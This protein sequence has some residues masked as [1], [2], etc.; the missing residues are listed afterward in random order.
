[1]DALSIGAVASQVSQDHQANPILLTNRTKSTLNPYTQDY[2]TAHPELTELVLVGGSK[3]LASSLETTL[4]QDFSN[5]TSISRLSGPNRFDT[6]LAIVEHY[7]PSPT[8]AVFVNGE[9]INLPGAELSATS[10]SSGTNF[11]SALLAG[12]F[13][14]TQS[15]PL[16]IVQ[17]NTL[18]TPIKQ[19]LTAHTATL[20]SAWIVGSLS[21]VS[22]AVEDSIE[23]FL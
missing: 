8:T 1:M 13:A 11:F 12:D 9:T 6:N 14:G 7:F 16:L 17:A 20:T 19:Y 23:A 4:K 5:L 15:A 22:Q 2:L 3:A 18:P 21:Q 10:A